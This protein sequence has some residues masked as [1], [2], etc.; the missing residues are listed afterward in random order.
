MFSVTKVGGTAAVQFYYSSSTASWYC[1]WNRGT[2]V[3][4]SS[5]VVVEE[6]EVEVEVEE[7]EEEEEAKVTCV[8][9]KSCMSAE[10]LTRKL[11]G[12]RI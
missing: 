10:Y 8:M 5:T 3:R 12:F 7:E 2:V 4:A 11:L 9:T 1:F 6:V